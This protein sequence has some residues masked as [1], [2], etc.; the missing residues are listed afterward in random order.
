MQRSEKPQSL[1][2]SMR[3]HRLGV[4]SSTS[5]LAERKPQ[6]QAIDDRADRDD[7]PGHAVRYEESI[8]IHDSCPI[9]MH[10]AAKVQCLDTRH[11]PFKSRSS[12]Q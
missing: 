10:Q 2:K 6:G 4:L 12:H 8:R 5:P 7:V 9:E 3:C 11:G 1:L